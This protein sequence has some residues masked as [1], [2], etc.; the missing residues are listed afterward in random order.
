[1]YVSS[2]YYICVHIL[3][4]MC[5]TEL[6]DAG[7]ELQRLRAFK[8]HR[9]PVAHRCVGVGVG[10]GVCVGV[11]VSLSLHP[12]MCVCVCVCVCVYFLIQIEAGR[13]WRCEGSSFTH[14]HD[15]LEF[16]TDDPSA[17]ELATASR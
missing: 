17:E 10:V 7:R 2:Y 4:Y 14:S 3:M 11:C 9:G 13:R 1:M 15:S 16:A 5:P 6:A 12:H 8:L